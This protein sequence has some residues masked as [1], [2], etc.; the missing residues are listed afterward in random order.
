MRKPMKFKRPPKPQHYWDNNYYCHPYMDWY[1]DDRFYTSYGDYRPYGGY[2]YSQHTKMPP[3]PKASNVDGMD[4]GWYNYS[5][6][7]LQ[8]C[9]QQG[10]QDGWAA[11]MAYCMSET[12]TDKGPMPPKP[13]PAP[14]PKTEE[15]TDQE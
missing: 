11:C 8:Q 5:P 6:D 4:N 15:T 10:F 9:Y 12:E 2:E 14:T 13:A 1:D 3:K 7:E